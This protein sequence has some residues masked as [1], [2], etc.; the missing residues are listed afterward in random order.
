MKQR[1]SVIRESRLIAEKN[2]RQMILF[3][4]NQLF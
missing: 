3:K 2:L 4:N 1:E